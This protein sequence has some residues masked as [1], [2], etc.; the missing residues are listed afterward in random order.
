MSAVGGGPYADSRARGDARLRSCTVMR[1]PS[2]VPHSPRFKTE[3]RP[4]AHDQSSSRRVVCRG[5]LFGRVLRRCSAQE[6]VSLVSK[7]DRCPRRLGSC[8]C[9]WRAVPCAKCLAQ[10]RLRAAQPDRRGRRVFLGNN[11][12]S[13][14]D[15]AWRS[16]T[17]GVLLSAPV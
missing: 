16:E 11:G 7:P 4:G 10:G 8:T 12:P 13:V 9:L 15:G 2:I 1:P 5:L 6:K 14:H 3:R 17:V